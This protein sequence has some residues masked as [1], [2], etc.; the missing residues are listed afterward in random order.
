MCDL[1]RHLVLRRWQF[2]LRPEGHQFRQDLGMCVVRQGGD[3]MSGG[4]Y[5]SAESQVGM[6]LVCSR[7]A[8]GLD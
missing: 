6:N 8:L 4:G 7:K 1:R 5:R 2:E 3:S